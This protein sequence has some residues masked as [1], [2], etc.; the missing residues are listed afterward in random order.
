MKRLIGAVI[1]RS[2]AQNDITGKYCRGIW[3]PHIGD[4]VGSYNYHID[5]AKFITFWHSQCSKLTKNISV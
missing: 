5:V 4:A 3:R 2:K 1:L